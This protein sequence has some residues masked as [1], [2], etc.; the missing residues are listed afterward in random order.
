VLIAT[1]LPVC[2]LLLEKGKKKEFGTRGRV[3]RREYRIE[4]GGRLGSGIPNTLDE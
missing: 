4:D 2:A 1:P 3:V